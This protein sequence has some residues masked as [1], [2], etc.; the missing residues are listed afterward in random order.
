MRPSVY[1]FHKATFTVEASSADEAEEEGDRRVFRHY[2]DRF[3]TV[4]VTR[5]APTRWAVTVT[6]YRKS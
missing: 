2:A 1:R 4:S 6:L 3:R 5:I